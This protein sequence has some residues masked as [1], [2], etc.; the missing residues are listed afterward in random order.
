MQAIILA[1]GKPTQLYCPTTDCPKSMVPLFDRPVMEHTI[2]WL[3]RHGVKDIVVAVS[4]LAQDLMEHFNDGSR[5]GVNIR[6]SIESEPLGTAGAVK[7][8][9]NMLDG[10]FLV[11]S[12]DVITDFDLKAAIEYHSKT[13]AVATILLGEADEPTQYGVVGRD[14]SGRVTRIIEKPKSGEVFSNTVSAG[15]YI[16]EPEVISCIPYDQSCDFAMRVFPAMLA[17]QER[18]FGLKAS[19]YW[20]DVGDLNNYRNLHF[21]ALVGK[22]KLDLH[23]THIGEGIWIGERVVIDPSAE[24]A[25][26]VYIGDGASIG[27]GTKLGERTIIGEGAVIDDHANISRSVIGR[28]SFVGRSSRIVNCVIG[29]GCSVSESENI[30]CQTILSRGVYEQPATHVT[31]APKPERRTAETPREADRVTI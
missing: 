3:A 27:R 12:G 11:I 5:W 28:K 19:G 16:C 29:G 31:P 6:Y 13:R 24:L 18:I 22:L 7:Q 20:C 1:G 25:A 30:S 2:Q 4:H 9:R 21:D 26:P 14:D 17:N 15:I 10:R 23:A 8:A